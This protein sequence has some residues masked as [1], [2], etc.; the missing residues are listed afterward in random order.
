MCQAHPRTW[1][2]PWIS[3]DPG[4]ICCRLKYHEMSWNAFA[5]NCLWPQRNILMS[6]HHQRVDLRSLNWEGRVLC[7]TYS[8]IHSVLSR[9][10]DPENAESNKTR[11]SAFKQFHVVYFWARVCRRRST[12]QCH[13][14]SE[15][16]KNIRFWDCLRLRNSLRHNIFSQ[17][18]LKASLVNFSLKQVQI[19]ARLLPAVTGQASA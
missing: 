14:S 5:L 18:L 12:P 13:H 16:N 6:P 15:S 19:L 2:V 7:C 8:S 10:S 4:C 17:R 3:F 11:T 9:R 1:S